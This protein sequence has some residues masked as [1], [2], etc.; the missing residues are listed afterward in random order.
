MHMLLF[1]RLPYRRRCT[2]GIDQRTS[3]SLPKRSFKVDHVTLSAE[4]ASL[5]RSVR[6]DF[7]VYPSH[8]PRRPVRVHSWCPRL[9]TLVPQGFVEAFILLT[10]SW[11]TRL[12]SVIYTYTSLVDLWCL[13]RVVPLMDFRRFWHPLPTPGRRC[14]RNRWMERPYIWPRFSRPVDRTMECCAQ[15][16]YPSS[17]A[18]SWCCSSLLFLRPNLKIA[19]TFWFTLVYW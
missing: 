6:T 12:V 3:S 15:L 9:L 19:F 8:Y 17:N 18:H 1:A 7:T 11:A 2:S 14:S 16:T 13:V 10:R 5:G 4:L